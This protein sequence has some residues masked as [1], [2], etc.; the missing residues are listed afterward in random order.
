LPGQAR[1]APMGTSPRMKEEK[2]SKL[3]GRSEMNV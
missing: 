2:L 3:Y 1:L